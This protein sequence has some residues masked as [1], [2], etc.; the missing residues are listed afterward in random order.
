MEQ[1]FIISKDFALTYDGYQKDENVFAYAV[2]SGV[3]SGDT[4]VC[5]VNA[6]KEF[7]EIFDEIN[8][9]LSKLDAETLNYISETVDLTDRLNNPNQYVLTFNYLEI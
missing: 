4:Y 7:P 2:L 9:D 5:S 1:Y 8:L 6:L 3:S